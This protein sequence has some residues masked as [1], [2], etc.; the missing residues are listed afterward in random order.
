MAASALGKSASVPYDYAIDALAKRW[1]V[2]PSVIEDGDVLWLIRGL[3]FLR[4]EASVRV[5]HE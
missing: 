1:H 4:L 5:G 3:E 2:H